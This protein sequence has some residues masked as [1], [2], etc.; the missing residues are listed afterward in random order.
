MGRASATRQ[1]LSVLETVYK[2]YYF[3]LLVMFSVHISTPLRLARLAPRFPCLAK[4]SKID[5]SISVAAKNSEEL[6]PNAKET[7]VI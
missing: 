2:L 1:E 7:N 5:N 3:Q 4:A 6:L